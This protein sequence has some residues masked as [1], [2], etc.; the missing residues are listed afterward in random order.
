[1]KLF[2]VL[3]K[4]NQ[5]EK[6]SFLKILDGFCTESRKITPQVDQILSQGA[7]QLKNVDDANIA[8]LFNLLNEKYSAH[9][10]KKLN[11]ATISLIL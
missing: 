4:V 3:S 10:E 1:M 8:K 11:L 5:I 6:I 7:N 2:K 9:L